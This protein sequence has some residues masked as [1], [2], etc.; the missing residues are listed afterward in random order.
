ML[1]LYGEVTR[2]LRNAYAARPQH[3]HTRSR[4]H[5]TTTSKN[6][7]KQTEKNKYL[8]PVMMNK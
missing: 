3:H 2:R 8:R 7:R 6:S 4:Q 1:E 5:D